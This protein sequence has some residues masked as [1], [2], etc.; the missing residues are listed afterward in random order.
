MSVLKLGIDPEIFSVDLF[1][2]SEIL[3]F[4]NKKKNY[5]DKLFFFLKSD[6]APQTIWG[7]TLEKS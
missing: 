7:K 5:P 2:K 4:Y 3:L 1:E 6:K